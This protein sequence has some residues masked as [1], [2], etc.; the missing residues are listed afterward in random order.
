MTPPRHGR[1][2][3]SKPRCYSIVVVA[4]ALVGGD[5]WMW[6]LRLLVVSVCVS[7]PCVSG[8][9]GCSTESRQCPE[10]YYG[11]DT[12]RDELSDGNRRSPAME[13][14]VKIESGE[15]EL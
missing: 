14:T 7:V 9:S 12:H 5:G 13:V 11:T 4:V 2:D 1:T 10:E 3:V 15:E 6:S 8:V